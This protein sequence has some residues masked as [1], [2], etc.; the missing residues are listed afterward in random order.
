M[1]IIVGLGNPGR[2]YEKTR[3]NVGY[4]AADALAKKIGV[5]AFRK[6]FRSAV[7]EGRIGAE[8]AVIAKPETYMNNSGFAVVDL[9]NWYKPEHDRLI[10]ILDD[11]DLPCGALRIRANGSAGTHNGM[12]SIVE[13]LGFEDFPRIRIGMGTPPPECPGGGVPPCFWQPGYAL[14]AS[15]T[16]S[17]RNS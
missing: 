11:I 10:V 15:L 12:R 17:C 4:M 14:L 6:A 3:H 16:E 9:L 8:K 13:Q 7:G 1:F 5:T 2:E